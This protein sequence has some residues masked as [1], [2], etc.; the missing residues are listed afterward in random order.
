MKIVS[1]A[2]RILAFFAIVSIVTTN[3]ER[4][5]RSLS[6]VQHILFQIDESLSSDTRNEIKSYVHMLRFNGKYNPAALVDHLPDRFACIAGIESQ[7]FA[8]NTAKLVIKTH[9]PLVKISDDQLVTMNGEIL[10]QRFFDTNLLSQL[11]LV[12]VSLPVNPDKIP[13]LVKTITDSI[14]ADLLKSYSMVWIDEHTIRLQDKQ[15]SRI[16]IVCSDETLPD[17]SMQAK[18]AALAQDKLSQKPNVRWKADI[19]FEDQI[20]V[21]M[22]KGGQNGTYV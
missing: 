6:S 4:V 12:Q 14:Q 9:E 15:N 20:I 8:H 18:C 2:V 13:I 17:E 10:S 3:L 7:T 1:E 22:D 21:S 16:T 5:S 19:R 11:D